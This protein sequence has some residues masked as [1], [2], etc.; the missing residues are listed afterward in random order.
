MYT[1]TLTNTDDDTGADNWTTMV[2]VY[3]PDA[4]WANADGSVRSSPG[5]LTTNP[6]AQGQAWWHLAAHYYKPHDT[7]PVG[8]ARTWLPGTNWRFDTF[9]DTGVDWLVVTPDGKLASKG[10]GQIAG[11]SGEYGYVYY[12]YDGCTIFTTPHCVPGPDKFRV[13]VWPLSEGAYPTGNAV[14]DNRASAGYDVD[15][16]EP[17]PVLSGLVTILRPFG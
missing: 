2:V 16:A 9:S 14:Y 5:S 13:V 3:D 10:H 4:G 11:L 8:D 6:T 1:I 17:Q 7:K 12:G 15:V